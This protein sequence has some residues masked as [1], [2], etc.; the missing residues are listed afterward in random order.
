MGIWCYDAGRPLGGHDVSGLDNRQPVRAHVAPAFS[1]LLRSHRLAAA[2]SQEAL[3]ERAGVSARG[4]ADLER[5][6]HRFP[7]PETL[8]R[9]A[10]ALALAPHE[11]AGFVDAGTRPRADS[12]A[13]GGRS[14][15][16]LPSPTT[17][18]VGRD[19]DLTEVA[20]LWSR[21]A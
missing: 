1:A 11:R 21:H 15:S 5:G 4:I 8:R 3:A 14:A 16:G 9:L 19:R 6:V 10:D 17:S 13:P 7:Y 20:A 12:E 2:L 18:F